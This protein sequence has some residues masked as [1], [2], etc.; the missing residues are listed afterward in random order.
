MMAA[1]ASKLKA[2]PSC[3]SGACK[4]R[5]SYLKPKEIRVWSIVAALGLRPGPIYL[6]LKT[7]GNPCWRQ[8]GHE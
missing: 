2:W 7:L 4:R 5:A 3:G 1:A 8:A 6:K